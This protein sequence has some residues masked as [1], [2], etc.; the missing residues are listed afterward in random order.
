MSEREEHSIKVINLAI[1][2]SVSQSVSLSVVSHLS[3]I[4]LFIRQMEYLFTI[5]HYLIPFVLVTFCNLM[6]LAG[7]ASYVSVVVTCNRR[8]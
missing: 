8:T 7:N 5:F 1:K 2:M 6:A 3:Q 4:I